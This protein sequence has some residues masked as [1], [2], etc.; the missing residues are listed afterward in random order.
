MIH[1]IITYLLLLILNHYKNLYLLILLYIHGFWFSRVF[2]DFLR[3]FLDFALVFIDFGWDVSHVYDPHDLIKG[4]MN[5]S[6]IGESIY[7][8]PVA[9]SKG[10]LEVIIGNVTKYFI[11]IRDDRPDAYFSQYD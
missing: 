1:N 5:I 7:G 8:G 2:I 9:N 11:K 4:D 6:D 10:D 3:G